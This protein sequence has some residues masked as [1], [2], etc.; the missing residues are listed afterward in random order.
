MAP[1]PASFLLPSHLHHSNRDAQRAQGRGVV[2]K[3]ESRL[4]HQQH[5]DP[6]QRQRQRYA[7]P[8]A[9]AQQQRRRCGNKHGNKEA[10]G[11]GI[12]QRQQLH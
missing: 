12:G 2:A 5:A 9:L 7:A 11:C 3:E 1:D 8:P 4:R 6:A 10:H